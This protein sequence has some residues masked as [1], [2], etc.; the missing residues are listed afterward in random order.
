MAID[1]ASLTLGQYALQANDP[2]I[3][4]IVDSLYQL[5]TLITE[6]PLTTTSTLQARGARWSGNLPTINYRKINEAT[7]V[8][9]GTIDQFNEQAYI[10]S[11][12]IDIDIRL[13]KDKNQI[14]D[15]FAVQT[16]GYFASLAYDFNDKFINNSPLTGDADAPVGIRTRLDSATDYGTSSTNKIDGAGVV[17]TNSLT[18]ASSGQFFELMDQML[19]EM[20]AP[21]GDNCL[22]ITNRLLRRRMQR[23]VKI[24]G[25]GGGFDMTQDAFGRRVYTYRNAR[26][27]TL[28]VKGDQSTEIITNTEDTAGADG[29]STYT[30]MYGVRLGE[31]QF[32]GWQMEPLAPQYIGQRSEEPTHARVFIDWA[33][34]LLQEHKR[35]IARVYDIKVA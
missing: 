19:D 8:A 29:S 9:S 22:I 12:A 2:V 10:V 34:G 1:S 15:P 13:L 23:G 7:V 11:N 5:D 16:M 35:A 6:I 18:A 32:R 28:G 30:S 21:N 33:V 20:G 14:S 25:A 24:M 26:L 3:L 17:M 31:G 4:K 27:V